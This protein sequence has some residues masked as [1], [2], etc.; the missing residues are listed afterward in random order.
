[1]YTVALYGCAS[2]AVDVHLAVCC[3]MC[4]HACVC[5]HARVCVY[6]YVCVCVLPTPPYGL[7]CT[8]RE[9]VLVNSGM[10]GNVM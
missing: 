3:V 4:V 7:V 1:M 5:M 10:P 9:V 8:V 6:S 2:V